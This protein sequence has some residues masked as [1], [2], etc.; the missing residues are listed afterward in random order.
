MPKE[1]PHPGLAVTDGAEIQRTIGLAEGKV[2]VGPI[3][4]T[5]FT[6][7]GNDVVGVHALPLYNAVAQFLV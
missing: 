1:A 4:I 7:K 6:G 5:H 2:F 3:I